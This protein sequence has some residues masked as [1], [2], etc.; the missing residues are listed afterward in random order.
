MKNIPF[1]IGG[2]R[3]VVAWGT[4]LQAGR[5]RLRVPMRWIILNLPNPP[6]RAMALGSTKPLT[7]MSTRNL[8]GVKGRAARRA[9]NLTAICEPIVY[10]LW[11]PHHLTTLWASTVCY[12]DSFTF[13]HSFHALITLECRQIVRPKRRWTIWLHGVTSQ[14]IVHFILT[15]T[16]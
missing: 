12:R 9:D 15:A 16:K 8:A 11:E 6:S 2:T 3:R 4:I 14:A 7:E 10:K 1:H 13:N 5:S